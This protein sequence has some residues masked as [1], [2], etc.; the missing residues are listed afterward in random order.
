MCYTKL[1]RNDLVFLDRK[2]R[3][4]RDRTEYFQP[5]KAEK[6]RKGLKTRSQVPKPEGYQRNASPNRVSVEVQDLHRDFETKHKKVTAS[7][8]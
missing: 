4:R 1:D 6:E 7:T 2:A 3:K 5:S 8:A